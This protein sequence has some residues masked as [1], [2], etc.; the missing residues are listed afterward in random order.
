[1]VPLTPGPGSSTPRFPAGFSYRR[2]AM[3][4]TTAAALRPFPVLWLLLA[5][6][7]LPP[8]QAVAQEKAARPKIGLVLGGGGAK[9]A[10]HV[11]VLKVIEELRV[12]VDC[13][14]GTSMGAIVGGMYASGMSP[15]EIETFLI[16]TDWNELFSDEPPRKDIGFRRK[17]EDFYNL[18]QFTIGYR[19]GRFRTAQSLFQAEKISLLLATL[20]LPAAGTSDFDRLPIPFR[21]VSADLETGDRV[22]LG[23]G[24]LS[25]AVRASMSL[26]GIFP[27]V[28]IDGRHLTDGGVVGNLPVEVVRDMGADVII[29][30]DVGKALL[31]RS[32]LRSSIAVMDQT[33]DIMIKKNVREETHL[34]GTR[35]VFI[36]PDL[37]GIATQDFERGVEAAARGQAAAREETGDL[38]RYAVSEEDYAAFL[39]RQRRPRIAS[40]RIGSVRTAGLERVSPDA[41]LHRFGTA[42]GEVLDP[43]TLRRRVGPVYGMGDFERIDLQVTPRDDVY[44]VLLRPQEKPWGPNYLR[45]GLSLESSFDG[46]SEY[47]MLID[48]TLR[49]VNRLGAEW[50]NQVQFGGR[51]FLFSEFYQPLFPTR[52][53]FFAPYVRWDQRFENLYLKDDV[54]A[55]YRIRDRL[56]GVDLGVQPWTYGEVRL[57]YVKETAQARLKVGLPLLP[58]VDVTQGGLRL[59][60]IV[61]QFDKVTF[62]REGYF[63]W[64]NVYSTRPQTGAV[65]PYDK[66]D[67]LAA[68]AS[69]FGP[70]TVMGNVRYGTHGRDDLPAFDQHHLGGFFNL[71]AYQRDQLFG[72]VLAFGKLLVYRRAETTMA[73]S[74]LGKFYIGG[75]L[76]AGNVW[77]TAS[78][79]AWD[80]VRLSASAF[81]AYDTIFGPLYIGTAVGDRGHDTIFLYLGNSFGS[82]VRDRF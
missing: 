14:A 39:R 21:A 53:L 80:D 75:S 6:F 69:T 27:P 30:V 22:V 50:R 43:D 46:G 71:S 55:Q 48:Y 72:Q 45:F 3:A 47:N 79:V 12:P 66:I 26:P 61:D 51:H 7:A 16:E 76:E 67:T 1:M 54:V 34:L 33:M 25:E 42:E 35:D 36:H 58:G 44:D 20:F 60:A 78:A 8:S 57:G 56:Y 81:I 23:N 32:E 24:R 10:A 73:G 15:A 29:A 82:L 52:T 70:Y 77:E 28:E 63:A 38:A 5:L 41:V 49:W 19:D 11:G 62:P 65:Q 59:R 2:M 37:G 40:V 64:L 31:A 9:G 4:H 68:A 18:S 74:L 13:I 17:S